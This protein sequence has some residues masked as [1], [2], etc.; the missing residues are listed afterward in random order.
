[1]KVNCI[2]E[3]GHWLNIEDLVFYLKWKIEDLK[4][5]KYKKNETKDYLKQS[6]LFDQMSSRQK[7][8]ILQIIDIECN[9]I[10]KL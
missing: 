4:K 8:K 2:T 1:M 6:F 9:L 7:E 10:F 5:M 3:D